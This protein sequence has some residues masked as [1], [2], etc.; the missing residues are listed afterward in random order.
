M[1]NIIRLWVLLV[2][3]S[4]CTQH[5]QAS[6]TPGHC[7]W[8]MVTTPPGHC[9]MVSQCLV[10]TRQL[11]DHCLQLLHPS[12][13]PTVTLSSILQSTVR[14]WPRLTRCRWELTMSTTWS[15][16]TTF[17]TSPQLQPPTAGLPRRSRR[18]SSL[19]SCQPREQCRSLLMISL[20]P[21][22]KCLTTF[23]RLSSGCSTSWMMLVDNIVSTILR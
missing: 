16:L 11:Q 14:V 3:V 10:P 2:E 5:L 21:F 20:E 6:M 12:A 19:V 17:T 4:Q 9:P 22:S 23:L 18:Y 1:I 8:P 13:P 15:D 7:R